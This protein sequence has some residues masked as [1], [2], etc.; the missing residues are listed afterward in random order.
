M[1]E[2]Y[3]TYYQSPIGLLKISGTE[4]FI[5]EV[6]FYDASHKQTPRNKHIPPLL[7]NCLEELIQYFNGELRNFTLPLNQ[8]GTT[9]QQDVWNL[10]TQIPFGKTISYLDLARKTGDSKA[11]RAVANANGK[12]HIAIIV[13]CHRVIGSNKELTGYAGGLWRKKWLL[14]HE[15]KVAYGVQTLF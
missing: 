6:S 9:F 2:T 7:I 8:P 13:P 10:L 12:N 3:T 1:A 15:A 4:M 14:D 11:T 5:S